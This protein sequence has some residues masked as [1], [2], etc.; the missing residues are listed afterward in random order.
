M[1]AIAQALFKSWFVDFDPVRA[2]LEG[3]EPEGLDAETAGLFPGKFEQSE[4]GA[5]P[6]GWSISSLDAVADYLSGLALQKFPPEEDSWLPVIKIAQLRKGDTYGADRAGRNLKPEYIVGDGDVLFSWSG[7]LEVAIWCGGKGALNQHLFKVTSRD[8][9]KWFYYFWTKHHLA[10]F[11]Q[12]AASKATTMG[13]SVP[14]CSFEGVR[15]LQPSHV[16]VTDFSSASIQ[17]MTF[18]TFAAIATRN[19]ALRR[20]ESRCSENSIN[21]ETGT[22]NMN[23]G[24]RRFAF[25]P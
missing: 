15:A 19:F 23:R 18:N 14:I 9:P 8:F 10:S 1:E 3:R 17:S 21:L 13:H 11:R 22:S 5:I 7:S 25:Y 4:L 2:K 12:I 24:Y 20:S 6:R 16:Y